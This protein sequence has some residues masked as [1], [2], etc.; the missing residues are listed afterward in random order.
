MKIILEITGNITLV[1][2]NEKKKIH[3]TAFLNTLS[4]K[5]AINYIKE[6]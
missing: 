5:D 6:V 2:Y 1:T 4:Y 3:K